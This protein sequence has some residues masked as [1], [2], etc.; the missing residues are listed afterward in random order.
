MEIYIKTL[1]HKHVGVISQGFIVQ[2][3][4]LCLSVFEVVMKL[5]CIIISVGVLCRV[6]LYCLNLKLD[7]MS[8]CSLDHAFLNDK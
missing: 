1:C 5:V 3:G 7:L 6:I 8:F 4:G 2:N